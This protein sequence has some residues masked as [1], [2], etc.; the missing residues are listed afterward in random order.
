MA[1]FPAKIATVSRPGAYGSSAAS[2]FSG[3]QTDDWQSSV[4][5]LGPV[6]FVYTS[7]AL[8]DGERRF[9]AQELATTHQVPL[10]IARDGRG[11]LH[12]WAGVEELRLP[13][14]IDKLFGAD[15]PF[16]DQLG[17]DLLRLCQHSDAG[18]IVLFGWRKGTTP[19]TFVVE[20]G[21]HAG[22]TPQETRAF[23]L[24]PG[25]V[26]LCPSN[27]D[28]LRPSDLRRAALIHLGRRQARP[29]P[30]RRHAVPA[31]AD[32][33]R[34]MTYNVHGCVGM[35]GKLSVERIARVIARYNPDVVAL[36]EL[37]VGRERSGGIDQADLIARYLEMD[38]HFHPSIHIEEERYGDAILTHLPMRLVKAAAL[39][40]LEASALRE[41]RGALWVAIDLH[42]KEL[43]L[44]NT[45]LGLNPRERLAQTEA[46]SGSEWL[47]NEKCRPPMI[48]CGDL[49]ASPRSPVCRLLQTRLDDVQTRVARHRPRKTFAGRLP[50]LRIDHIFIEPGLEVTGIE[51]PSSQLVQVASDHLPLIA[52]LLIPPGNIDG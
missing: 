40:G 21:S 46:L 12:A 15:H 31:A 26:S 37:D 28:Y 45:H 24:I 10:V 47:A 30:S 48:L 41:P 27:P 7:R 38:F 36:Q 42:G 35:D 2:G 39:P 3:S 32:R 52:E 51:V 43:Q 49:N 18:E 8:D 5:A 13:Q 14:Q 22:A 50:T 34:V 23:A 11:R 1:T 6:G 44:I 17:D 20:N 33:L 29:E 16:L 25:D 19:V 4:A 9:V